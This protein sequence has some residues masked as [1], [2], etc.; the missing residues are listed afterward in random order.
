LIQIQ[1]KSC[2]CEHNIDCI[3]FVFVKMSKCLGR[4]HDGD[5]SR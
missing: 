2:L 5:Q 3:K 4:E 1:T